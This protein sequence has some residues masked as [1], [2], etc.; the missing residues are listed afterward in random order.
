VLAGTYEI[1]TFQDLSGQLSRRSVSIHFPRYGPGEEDQK[2]FQSVLYAFQR[3]L[4]VMEEPDLLRHWEYCY[5]RSIGCVGILR[6]WLVRALAVSM[7][8]GDRTVSLRNLEETALSVW[9]CEQIPR[10]TLAGEER[11]EE[12]P[13]LMSR[14][15]RQNHLSRLVRISMVERADC[16]PYLRSCSTSLGACCGLCRRPLP[17]GT[18]GQ[19]LNMQGAARYRTH[20]ASGAYGAY[21]LPPENY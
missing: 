3:Q 2:V 16:L 15:R 10:G 5:V 9:Q 4:L 17:K 8:Q 11:L 18:I 7:E 14:F 13:G 6:D 1:L 19:A 21:G 20:D 12:K